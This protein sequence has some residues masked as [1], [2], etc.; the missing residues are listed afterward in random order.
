MLICAARKPAD[1]AGAGL[2]KG[3]QKKL[4]RC[5]EQAR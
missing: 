3:V 2:R 1:L 4:G 5:L